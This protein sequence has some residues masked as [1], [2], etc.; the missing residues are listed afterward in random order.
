M[1]KATIYFHDNFYL[2]PLSHLGFTH[3][4]KWRLFWCVS[5]STTA[6]SCEP[7]TKIKT[8]I[9]SFYQVQLFWNV[10]G[11]LK[12]CLQWCQEKTGYL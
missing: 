2:Y 3:T 4:V 7:E 6:Y 11:T 9:R 5:S 1:H 10:Y 8:K 12:D